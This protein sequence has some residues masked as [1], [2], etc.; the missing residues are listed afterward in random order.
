[1]LNYTCC[2]IFDKVK[3][4]KSH[5]THVKLY[6]I[7]SMGLCVMRW[8]GNW[9]LTDY[10]NQCNWMLNNWQHFAFMMRKP[11]TLEISTCSIQFTFFFFIFFF[12]LKNRKLIFSSTLIL[13][14]FG[15]IEIVVEQTSVS[16]R[17]NE[18]KR[19]KRARDCYLSPFSV[20][21]VKTTKKPFLNKIGFQF[22]IFNFHFHRMDGWMN[23]CMAKYRVIIGITDLHFRN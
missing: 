21:N 23:E 11:V 16:E 12:F 13:S 3:I 20:A 7:V 6:Y 4:R 18:S 19:R 10:R 1:M 14:I 5:Y 22:I 8:K 9:Y 17:T 2:I 15:W